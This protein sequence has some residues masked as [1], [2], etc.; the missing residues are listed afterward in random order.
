VFLHNIRNQPFNIMINIIVNMFIINKYIYIYIYIYLY[1][2][3]S[4]L[5]TVILYSYKMYF[6]KNASH[7]TNIK[8]TKCKTKD[9]I[10][11]LMNQDKNI[12]NQWV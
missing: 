12:K 1:L 2:Y 7:L 8:C 9:A 5:I 11:K 3:L 6:T 4:L 10:N